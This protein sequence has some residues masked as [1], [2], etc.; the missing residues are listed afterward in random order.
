MDLSILNLHSAHAHC[1]GDGGG[2][3]GRLDIRDHS[4]VEKEGSTD[5]ISDVLFSL[6][7][8]TEL[9]LCA[10]ISQTH[11]HE[12]LHVE[13]STEHTSPLCD[14]HE[15]ETQGL[16]ILPNSG[17]A[18][19]DYTLQKGYFISVQHTLIMCSVCIA[20]YNLTHMC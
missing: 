5:H 10:N 17:P 12:G 18:H 3:G 16:A 6:L 4:G 13:T 14:V 15:L 9:Q 1:V 2:G 8:S 11:C 20:L 7:F 19:T